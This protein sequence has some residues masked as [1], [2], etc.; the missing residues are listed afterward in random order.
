MVSEYRFVGGEGV[1]WERT[2][3]ICKTPEAVADALNLFL[4]NDAPKEE[5]E[6]ALK[7][8]TLVL[9]RLKKEKGSRLSY[10]AAKKRL[11]SIMEPRALGENN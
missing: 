4:P 7:Q 2:F 3:S 6:E 10:E 9:M 1:D 11:L 5:W 8:A